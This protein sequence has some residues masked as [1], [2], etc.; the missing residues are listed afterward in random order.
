MTTTETSV[1]YEERVTRD[2]RIVEKHVTIE[3]RHEEGYRWGPMSPEDR[4]ARAAAIAAGVEEVLA[5]YWQNEAELNFPVSEEQKRRQR[6]LLSL[7]NS[8]G[9]IAHERVYGPPKI[10][11]T[12]IAAK[13]EK[14]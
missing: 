14:R 13:K 5:P 1:Q 4:D 2:E 3:Y 8:C 9:V 12:P 7:G 6:E 10:T 11:R